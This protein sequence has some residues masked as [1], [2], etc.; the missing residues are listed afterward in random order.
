[1]INL[2]LFAGFANRGDLSC[3]LI[4]MLFAEFHIRKKIFGATP[5]KE[6]DMDSRPVALN[7]FRG[8][9]WILVLVVGIWM[10]SIPI[11]QGNYGSSTPGYR[12]ISK[13]IPLND[14]VMSIGMALMFLGIY[15]L[16]S[17]QAFF[18]STLMCYLGDISFSLYLIHWP[19]LA[20]GAWNMVPVLQ[21]VTGGHSEAGFLLAMA[22][23]TPLMLWASDLF[24]RLV[25]LPSIRF[26]KQLEKQ[27]FVS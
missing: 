19:I 24:W 4:G 27:L 2:T 20:A 23:T 11:T 17:L 9:V 5:S 7:I 18:S 25:D 13:L 21:R 6:I 3:F 16:P 22:V 1:M 15:K 10:A 26:A 14:N 12:T 8:G